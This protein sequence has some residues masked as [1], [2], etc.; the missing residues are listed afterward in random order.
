[1]RFDGWVEICG[2]GVRIE[3]SSGPTVQKQ[4][5]KRR[6]RGVLQRLSNHIAGLMGETGSGR[7]LWLEF[8]WVRKL[9]VINLAGHQPSGWLRGQKITALG[10]CQVS[11]VGP[12][13]MSAAGNF[14]LGRVC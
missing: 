6:L 10:S 14:L 13:L 8:S 11:A 5:A 3:E 4:Q 1:M 9:L 7:A 2:Q 12:A